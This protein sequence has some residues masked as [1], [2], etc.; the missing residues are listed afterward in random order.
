VAFER[1]VSGSEY[2]IELEIAALHTTLPP[3]VTTTRDGFASIGMGW[4][5]PGIFTGLSAMILILLNGKQ[6]FGV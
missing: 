4:S 2:W 6:D 5:G 1:E 3:T